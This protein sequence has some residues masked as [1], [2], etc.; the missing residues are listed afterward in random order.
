MDGKKQKTKTKHNWICLNYVNL[1]S[2]SV[3]GTRCQ[4]DMLNNS[5]PVNP[6]IMLSYRDNDIEMKN[7]ICKHNVTINML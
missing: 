6:A 1:K 2:D 3:N 5:T 4:N 7:S